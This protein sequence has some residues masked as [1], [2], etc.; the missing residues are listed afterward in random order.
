MRPLSAPKSQPDPMIDPAEAHIRPMN[1]ICRFSPVSGSD[2][3]GDV[4]AVA[5][6]VL[7]PFRDAC[8]GNVHAA[9]YL[10]R[11]R[12]YTPGKGPKGQETR[13]SHARI[14]HLTIVCH[15]D[16]I[17]AANTCRYLGSNDC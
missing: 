4:W 5:I 2:S 1:P 7:L 16:R 10:R 8:T 14:E 6:E 15:L 17:L 11:P 12:S 13:S 3:L 9:H